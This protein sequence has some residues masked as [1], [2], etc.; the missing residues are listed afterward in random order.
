MIDTAIGLGAVSLLAIIPFQW[1]SKKGCAQKFDPKNSPF[2]LAFSYAVWLMILY[3]LLSFLKGYLSVQIL[4]NFTLTN[5]LIGTGIILLCLGIKII[6]KLTTVEHYGIGFMLTG[7]ITTISTS[8]GLLFLLISIVGI[9]LAN[10]FFLGY[11]IG[12]VTL[13]GLELFNG[14]FLELWPI[15]LGILIGLVIIYTTEIIQLLKGKKTD[16]FLAYKNRHQR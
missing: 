4:Q 12:V 10:H 16:L 14:Q 2:K 7:V 5:S 3:P 15:Y 9:L 11:L 1:L 8:Y 6:S 13:V